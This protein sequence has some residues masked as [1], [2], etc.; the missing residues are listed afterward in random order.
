MSEKVVKRLVQILAYA[1]IA[2]P[3]A[4]LGQALGPL[5]LNMGAICKEINEVTS[6]IRAGVPLRINLSYFHDSTYKL[7]IMSP[8]SS[9]MLKRAAGIRVKSMQKGSPAPGHEEV[10]LVSIKDIYDIAVMKQ[11][12]DPHMRHIPLESIC[13][14]TTTQSIM[15]TCSSMG[16]IVTE[17]RSKPPPMDL[18]LRKVGQK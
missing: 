9:W 16:I 13:R 11:T 1:Q 15:G 7:D 10:G 8:P 3:T 4:K 2:K 12:M 14:V 18:P 5:G 6:N 17:D